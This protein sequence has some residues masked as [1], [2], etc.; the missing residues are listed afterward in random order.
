MLYFIGWSLFLIFFKCYLHR[1]VVGRENVPAKG[2]F[3]FASNHSSYFDPILLGTAIFRSLNY[4]ARD[5][6]FRKRC[7]GWVMRQLHSFPVKRNAGD[8]GAIKTAL[9]VLKKGKPLVVF[10]E[11]T[12]TKDEN[13]KR[14]KPGIGYIVVK[15]R[16]PVVPAYIAGSFRALPRGAGTLKRYPVTVYI[17]RP[18]Y[19][20][21][22][23]G[24]RDKAVYQAISNEIMERISELKRRH[25]G[26]AG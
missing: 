22:Y 26:K 15:S 25:E 2:A 10:P 3:I 4:M 23:F 6:L 9:K 8:L 21:R 14:G 20:D 11:G 18:L 19:F 24:K 16:V 13:L 5:N 17:G 12:R 1:K 7:F